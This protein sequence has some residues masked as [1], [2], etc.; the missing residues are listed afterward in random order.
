MNTQ[1]ECEKYKRDTSM[2]L[3]SSI[4]AKLL[5]IDIGTTEGTGVYMNV[6]EA[7]DRLLV[8]EWEMGSHLVS[9]AK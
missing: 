6:V 3:A 2:I 1:T 5:R 7:K 8:T 4:V 9:L